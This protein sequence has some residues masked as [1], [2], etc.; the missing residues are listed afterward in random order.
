MAPKLGP[1][2]PAPA[3]LDPF[4]TQVSP[5][6]GVV[7]S[8]EVTARAPQAPTLGVVESTPSKV[9]SVALPA[10]E[11]IGIISQPITPAPAP[12]PAPPPVGIVEDKTPVYPP[13]LPLRAPALGTVVDLSITPRNQAQ[14]E[15]VEPPPAIAVQQKV[16]DPAA[17]P[18]PALGTVKDHTPKRSVK[19]TKASNV[20]QPV[21]LDPFKPKED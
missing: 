2:P 20:S 12:P 7:V 17:P 10:P 14:D 3:P 4:K 9:I 11:T 5:P 16:V 1:V 19:K 13:P 18:A 15:T 6:L 8:N 21:V